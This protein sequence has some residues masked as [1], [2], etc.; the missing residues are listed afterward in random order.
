MS[1]LAEPLNSSSKQ[2]TTSTRGDLGTQEC[3]VLTQVTTPEGVS[4]AAGFGPGLVAGAVV[5]KGD[6]GDNTSRTC[7]VY[8]LSALFQP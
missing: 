8:V 2:G 6:I 7:L 1:T 3:T 4:S 5:C